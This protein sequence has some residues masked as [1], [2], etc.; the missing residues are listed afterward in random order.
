MV[1]LYYLSYFKVISFN[2]KKEIVS[3]FGNLIACYRIKKINCRV[4]AMKLCFSEYYIILHFLIFDNA[5]LNFTV[6]L[7]YIGEGY[8]VNQEQ[9]F[10]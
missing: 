4:N 1:I 10:K 7:A 3:N 5:I 8:I 2:V 6:R 9:F